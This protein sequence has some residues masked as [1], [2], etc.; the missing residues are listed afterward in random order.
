MPV[1]GTAARHAEV[2]T[3]RI[4]KRWIRGAAKDLELVVGQGAPLSSLL[5]RRHTSSRNDGQAHG[6]AIPFPGNSFRYENRVF[7]ERT[8]GSARARWVLEYSKHRRP[9]TRQRGIR[10]S[11][12]E[13]SV[14]NLFQARMAAKNRPF[15]II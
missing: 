9:A 8:S 12:L 14:P 7:R 11:S 15:K 10:C 13:Q 5:H 3:D 6:A 1:L 4:A 2:R